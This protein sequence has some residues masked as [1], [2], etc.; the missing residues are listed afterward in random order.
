MQASQSEFL[1]VEKLIIDVLSW[2]SAQVC[3]YV[4]YN[5]MT[6]LRWC[7]HQLYKTVRPRGTWEVGVFRGQVLNQFCDRF[8]RSHPGDSKTASHG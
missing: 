7:H 1:E 2:C 6:T 5:I 4:A 8:Q 3:A